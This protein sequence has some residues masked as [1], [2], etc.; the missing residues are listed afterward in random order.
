[1]GH[2]SSIAFGLAKS[3]PHR[4]IVCI[5]GDG[6][7][8]MHMGSLP[9]IGQSNCSNLLHVLLNN[10]A[11]ESVGGQPTCAPSVDFSSLARA[12]GYSLS[13]TVQRTPDLENAL[14]AYRTLEQPTFI[15]VKTSLCSSDSLGRPSRSHLD[16]RLA[17]MSYISS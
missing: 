11:H 3:L 16:N 10:G 7:L 17:F 5:D 13:L 9:S 15:E 12:C 6:A 1:M 2:A 8:L 14:D 4:L